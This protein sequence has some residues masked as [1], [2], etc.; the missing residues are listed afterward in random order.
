LRPFAQVAG[1]ASS[2]DWTV[3]RDL[4]PP[5]YEFLSA[6]DGDLVGFEV[7]GAQYYPPLP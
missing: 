4:A 5:V 6:L 1:V 3:P 7:E 2:L